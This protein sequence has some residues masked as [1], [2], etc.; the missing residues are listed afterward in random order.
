MCISLVHLLT[1]AIDEL[2]EF[3]T[4]DATIPPDKF[5]PWVEEFPA[6]LVTLAI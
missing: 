1:D 3:Y 6:Q 5:M 4:A 2:Q